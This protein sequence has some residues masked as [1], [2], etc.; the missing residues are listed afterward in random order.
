MVISS[1]RLHLQSVSK[2]TTSSGGEWWPPRIWIRPWAGLPVTM[3]TKNKN[4]RNRPW[5]LSIV[6][7]WQTKKNHWILSEIC[8]LYFTLALTLKKLKWRKTS[9]LAYFKWLIFIGTHRLFP[10]CNN[11]ILD[12]EIIILA[13]KMNMSVLWFFNYCLFQNYTLI[14]YHNQLFGALDLVY[15]GEKSHKQVVFQLKLVKT[16]YIHTNIHSTETNVC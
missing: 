12:F 11:R 13:R 15:F 6:S 8:F 4:S 16:T 10:W 5:G 14:S 9:D 1:S 7:K 2:L 3:P